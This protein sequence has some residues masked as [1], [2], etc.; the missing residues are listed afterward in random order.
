MGAA[1][2]V[3]ADLETRVQLMVERGLDIIVVDTAHGH[4]RGVLQAIRRIKAIAPHLPVIGGT[5]LPQRAR[6]RLSKPA[7]MRSKL[8]LGLARFAPRASSPGPVMPQLSAIYNCSQA[9]RPHG[10]PIIADGGVKYSGD[11]VKA[12]AAGAETVSWAASWPP[13]RVPGN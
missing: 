3:G 11:I 6:W 10:I 5:W 9:A 2:G 1:V 13:G 12:I 8:A 7:P 4:S